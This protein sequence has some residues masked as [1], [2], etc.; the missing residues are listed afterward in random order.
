MKFI[1]TDGTPH[2]TN[3]RSKLKEIQELKDSELTAWYGYEQEY[4]MFGRKYKKPVGWPKHGFPH[5]QGDYYCGVGADYVSGRDIAY[6]HTKKCLE[7]GIKI[8]GINA[9]VMLG[10]WEYQVGTVNTIDGADDLWVSRYILYR[11]GEKHNVYVN[12]DPKPFE[13][14]EWNGSGMHVNFSTEE[15][16]NSDN[17][18]E[19][20]EDACNK[21][22]ET[23]KSHI[24]VY[25]VNNDKRY[26]WSQ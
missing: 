8:S 23:H 24:E 4:V 25:G 13:G 7:I 9:E 5:A 6:E 22:K 3:T 12:I 18:Q 15:M 10:Q 11:I 2:E 14:T 19:L 16:R 17:K 20:I 21:L 26:N 1:T